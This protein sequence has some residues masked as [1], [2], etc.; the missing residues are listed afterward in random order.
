MGDEG[1]HASSVKLET[2][3]S[4]SV[5]M[6]SFNPGAYLQEAVR[7]VLDQPQCLELI[8]ADGGST[9][10]SVETLEDLARTDTRLKLHVAPD[11]GPADALNTAFR[12]A[13]GTLIGWLNADDL[14]PPGA[15][16]RAVAALE[17]HP[18][19]LMVYGEGEEFNDSNGSRQRYPSQPATVG[20]QGFHSHCFICQ[21][22]VV[23]R[24]SMGILLGPFDT[25]FTTAFDFDYWMR[26]FAAF[27]DRIGY[28]PH[29]QGLTR[30]HQATITSSQRAQVAIE[31]TRLLA[32]HFGPAPPDRLDG[33]CLELQRGLAALPPGISRTEHLE[34]LF[35]RAEP[36]LA[37]HALAH[38]RQHWLQGPGVCSSQTR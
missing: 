8:V 7:S 10:G 38:L 28:V 15:L 32:R 6:P 35:A 37:P 29:L 24:R 9:D 19:W 27:P 3:P 13:R 17:F 33:Y 36:W 20:L 5:L 34:H 4:V 2:S 30:I 21:P 31:A 1:N 25:T 22:T 11:H 16:A 18:H 14:Y 12:R 26:A 23:F